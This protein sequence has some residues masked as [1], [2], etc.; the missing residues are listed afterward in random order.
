MI[1]EWLSRSPRSHDLW[2]VTLCVAIGRSYLLQPKARH[3]STHFSR[4]VWRILTIARELAHLLH[5]QHRIERKSYETT[6]PQR[7][8]G[9][10]SWHSGLRS[11]LP[12]SSWGPCLA[13]AGLLSWFSDCRPLAWT[14]M[15]HHRCHPLDL[16]PVS[17]HLQGPDKLISC[18]AIC[19]LICSPS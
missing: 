13:A 7:K 12:V 9:P 6:G 10:V 11:L 14:V 17:H 16:E 18:T 5:R 8:P 2:P 3:S 1:S 4:E 19:F 15:S